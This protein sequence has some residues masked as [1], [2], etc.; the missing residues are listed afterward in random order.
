MGRDPAL[1]PAV[2]D[3]ASLF[4]FRYPVTPRTAPVTSQNPRRIT[5]LACPSLNR[6]SRDGRSLDRSPR[7]WLSQRNSAGHR[8]LPAAV[9]RP[10]RV[11]QHPALQHRGPAHSRPQRSPSSSA[12]PAGL[13]AA[14][15]TAPQNL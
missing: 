9:A 12:A 4:T 14:R 15:T 5:A 1:G 8:S 7:D 11:L 10:R 13:A 3:L 6:V 2:S